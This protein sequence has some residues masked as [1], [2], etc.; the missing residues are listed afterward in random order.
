[1]PRPHVTLTLVL[2][3]AIAGTTARAD[4]VVLKN[5]KTLMGTIVKE[6]PKAVTIRVSDL[7]T[8]TIHPGKKTR[9]PD[10]SRYAPVTLR[11]VASIFPKAQRE[12]GVICRRRASA[13]RS[14]S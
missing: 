7:G 8:M 14:A 11:V 1:M 13:V 10:G 9:R 3:L 6:T 12:L 4:S 2:L 5:G